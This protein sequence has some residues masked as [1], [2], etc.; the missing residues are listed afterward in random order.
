M[1]TRTKITFINE[2]AVLCER[3]S[4]DVITVSQGMGQDGRI[5]NKFLH[6]G[7]SPHGAGSFDADA[8]ADVAD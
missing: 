7:P 1:A 3:T 6:A 2:I 8:D 4:A 5:G